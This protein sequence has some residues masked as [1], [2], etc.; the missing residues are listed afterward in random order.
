MVWLKEL[1]NELVKRC[2]VDVC[3]LALP[4]APSTFSRRIVASTPSLGAGTPQAIGNWGH[5]YTGPKGRPKHE[6][7]TNHGFWKAT[8]LG[9]QN[10]KM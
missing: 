4:V 1:A 8:R 7:P 6:D 9:P 5:R 3:G 10:Q 2:S